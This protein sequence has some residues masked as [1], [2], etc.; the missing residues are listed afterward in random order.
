MG[1]IH[2]HGVLAFQRGTLLPLPTNTVPPLKTTFLP[3]VGEIR[4]E[5]YWLINR[6]R[7]VKEKREYE[8][9]H[10]HI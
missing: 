5:N 4:L 10:T 2:L 9:L 3:K 8:E 7:A 6:N 1:E